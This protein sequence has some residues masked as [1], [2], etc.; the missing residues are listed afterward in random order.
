MGRTKSF[1]STRLRDKTQDKQDKKYEPKRK[2][3]KKREERKKSK[4]RRGRGSEAKGNSKGRREVKGSEYILY[5]L[6]KFRR[7]LE[8][9][10]QEDYKSGQF[11]AVC[12]LTLLNLKFFLSLYFIYF[13]LFIYL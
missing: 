3:R 6:R 8:E 2:K 4:G 11:I 13:N 1:H 10:Q 7:Q 9:V 5:I 12:C